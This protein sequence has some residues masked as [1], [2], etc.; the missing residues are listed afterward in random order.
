MKQTIDYSV[1]FC[2]HNTFETDP[3]VAISVD[4][5][6]QV[7]GES[8]VAF[9]KSISTRLKQIMTSNLK[10]RSMLDQLAF[11]S[12]RGTYE[13]HLSTQKSDYL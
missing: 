3:V 1:R 8:K 7:W 12:S 10:S 11:V 9:L 6:T 2:I 13:S 5:Q 4:V